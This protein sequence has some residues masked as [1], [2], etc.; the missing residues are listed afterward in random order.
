[1]LISPE[2]DGV[3]CEGVCRSKRASCDNSVLQVPLT[4][5]S[6]LR[7]KRKGNRVNCKG[8]R[9]SFYSLVKGSAV[10]SV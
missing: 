4:Y 9:Q 1:M 8:D 3:V 10:D 6:V 7:A 5:F 2:G